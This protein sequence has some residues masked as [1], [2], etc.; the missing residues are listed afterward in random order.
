MGF[1]FDLPFDLPESGTAQKLWRFCTKCMAMFFDGDPAR[2]GVCSAGGGHS[3]QGFMFVLPHDVPESATAQG[4]W[5]FCTKC[6]AMFFDGDPARKGICPAGAGHNAQG[7]MFVLPHHDEIQVFDTGP[8]TSNLPLGG[9][10]QIVIS[11]SGT[12][13][14]K[15]HAHD[16]GFDNINYTLGAV[17][18]TPSGLAF[19]IHHQGSVEGT[20]GDLLGTPRRDDDQITTESNQAMR[21]EFGNLFNSTFVGKLAGT[22]TLVGGVKDLIEDALKAAASQLGQAAA[23][24]VIAL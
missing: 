18:M 17:L 10:A 7:F 12:Y 9:S 16:S 8:I 5:R 1:N 2:K 24:A 3:A 6:M 23:K 11:K 4:N 15:S 19:T 13:T 22:D 20:S 21:D 14:F